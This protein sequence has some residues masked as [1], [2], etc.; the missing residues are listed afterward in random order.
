MDEQPEVLI[1]DRDGKLGARFAAVFG[2][3]GARAAMRMTLVA[4]TGVFT[5]I[6]LAAEG[7]LAGARMGAWEGQVG[8]EGAQ[9]S[10][11]AAHRYHA[12][13]HRPRRRAVSPTRAAR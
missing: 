1:T 2:G 7:S 6:A 5:G 4:S 3:C 11:L 8:E 13:R 10:A 12:P 9:Q